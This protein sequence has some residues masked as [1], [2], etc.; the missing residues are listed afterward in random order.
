M[1]VCHCGAKALEGSDRCADHHCGQILRMIRKLPAE[2]REALFEQ[3][4]LDWC[5]H[6]GCDQPD[7][8]YGRRCQCEND[9]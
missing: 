2:K 5:I 7:D 4:Q 1:G 9:E 6:C 8:E 3:I